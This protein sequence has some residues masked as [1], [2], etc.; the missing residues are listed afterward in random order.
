MILD[1]LIASRARAVF[2]E[3]RSIEWRIASTS[4]SFGPSVQAA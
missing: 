3:L 2:A 4:D 1:A